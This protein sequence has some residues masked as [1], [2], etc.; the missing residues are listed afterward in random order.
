MNQKDLIQKINDAANII[1]KSN[2]R[3]G[4]NYIIVSTQ[5]ADAMEKVLDPDYK[6]KIREKKLRRILNDNN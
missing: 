6:R 2:I 1:H 3:G 4:S 5:V